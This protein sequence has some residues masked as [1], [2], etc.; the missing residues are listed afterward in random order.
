LSQETNNI[1]IYPLFDFQVTEALTEKIRNGFEFS[2]KVKLRQITEEE[3][4]QFFELH[5][6]L[7][8]EGAYLLCIINT[9]TW[10]LEIGDTVDR[11]ERLIYEILLALRLYKDGSV[12]AKIA[13]RKEDS[14]IIPHFRFP[15]TPFRPNTYK[16]DINDI[17]QVNELINGVN[18]LDLD[19]NNPFRVA[20]ERFSRSFEERRSDDRIIDLAIAFEALFVDEDLSRIEHM[21]KFV[22]IGC[23]MLLG[24]NIQERKE[25]KQFLTK[26]FTVRNDIVHSLKLNTTIKVDNKEYKINDFSIQL[27][28]YLRD[29]IKQLM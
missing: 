3:I 21:G 13:L 23:S 20:C 17:E 2:N 7:W 24:N 19:H 5:P 26:A 15:P 4:K 29:S 12:F 14:K 22:G 11:A 9:R 18:N 16:L 25:I 1:I 6:Y 8:K 27:Q 10:V 28:K